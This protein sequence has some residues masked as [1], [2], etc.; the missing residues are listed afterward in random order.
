V[1][2]FRERFV[3]SRCGEVLVGGRVHVPN[4][5][6]AIHCSAAQ[7]DGEGFPQEEN[8][9]ADSRLGVLSGLVILSDHVATRPLKTMNAEPELTA[10]KGA[11]DYRSAV[12]AAITRSRQGHWY[13]GL[14]ICLPTALS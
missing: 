9:D 6:F 12:N 10:H 2:I 11:D 5:D 1:L 3:L 13:A 4:E 7:A 14:R 8:I